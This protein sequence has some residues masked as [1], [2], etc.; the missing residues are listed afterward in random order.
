M[1][2]IKRYN[3]LKILLDNAGKEVSGEYMSRKLE[4]SRVAIAKHIKKMRTMGCNIQARPGGGYTMIEAP[5]IIC[6]EL[7]RAYG[8]MLLPV[9]VKDV[10]KSTNID[11]KAWA[12]NNAEHGSMIVAKTQTGGRGRRQRQ[13]QS[14]EGGIW[15]SIILKTNIAPSQVQPIT[16]AAA[17]AVVQAITQNSENAK[18]KI[19]WP[20]DILV[21]GKKVC[22]ILTEFIGDIDE[23][24]YLIIGIGIN[25]AFDREQL[26]G[27]LLNKATTLQSENII[28]SSSKLIVD[29]RDNLLEITDKW[30]ESNSKK[31]I[32]DFYREN[33]A[34]K[35][36]NIK[37]SGAGEDIFGV[38]ED[39]DES[40]ALIIST[41]SGTKKIISGEISVRRA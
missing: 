19:K 26:E 5:Q 20:N 6:E 15:S 31:H 8:N 11:A 41:E 14:I 21:N 10:V 9:M 16:L 30:S 23:L 40:G 4:I 34:Y 37:I 28:I 32:I 12:E 17:M 3:I 22:G 1:F 13:W 35:N 2:N 18:P 33:M 36:E 38:L 24:R 39:I 29:V 7:I 27:E 25:N